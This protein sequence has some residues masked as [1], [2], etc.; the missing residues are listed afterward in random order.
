MYLFFAATLA[1]ASPTDMATAMEID[2]NDVAGSSFVG[3]ASAWTI[4]NNFG[5]INPTQ[6]TTMTHLYTGSI[7]VA[8]QPG[9][10]LG[11]WGETND[12]TTLTLT[13]NAPASAQSARFDF[14]FL[15]AEYPEYVGTSYNDKFEANISSSAWSGNAAI[16]SLG[17]MVS[18]NTL[19]FSVVD[20]ASLSGTGF[21][22]VDPYSGQIHG[23]GTGWLSLLF[24]VSP[25]ETVTV[26]FTVYDVS[27]GI[28]DSAVL[29]DNF[30]W[31][32]QYVG[33]PS[34]IVPVELD[35]LS[36]KRST[37][38]GGI[39]TIV[40]GENFQ[41]GCEVFF[42]G[43]ASSNV[44]YLDPNRLEAMVPPHAEG[45]VD[46][47]VNCYDVQDQLVGAFTYYDDDG[48][49][50]PPEVHA[51]DPYQVYDNGGETVIVTGSGFQ[52]G[53]VCSVDEAPVACTVIGGQIIEF[54]TPAHAVG[55]ADVKV[56]NPDGLW[57][58]KNGA[59]Y[60]IPSP[61]YPETDDADPDDSGFT[62]TGEDSDE[63]LDAVK[64][65][66]SG[67]C[68]HFGAVGWLCIL[69]VG[70]GLGRRRRR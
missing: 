38:D 19:F 40:H 44:V 61:D 18:I 3:D 69:G 63:D 34:I 30:E 43:Q 22:I 66:S 54:S 33:V 39:T 7:G 25:G 29:L 20:S 10:D 70:A 37:I 50:V 15:S 45:I 64:D 26:E 65:G 9:T 41:N 5:V 27:D 16:D 31:S 12:R 58:D 62:D 52:N 21:D 2:P 60:Y 59:L 36:P 48:G 6:S 35:Y 51:V 24:P 17:N 11:S 55:F 56:E 28:Y 23:G 67:G 13:L 4:A 14:Y 32:N 49:S 53:A 47:S 42:D 1:Y 46:V 8:P 68:S 57:D